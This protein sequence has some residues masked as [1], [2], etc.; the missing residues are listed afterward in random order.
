MYYYKIGLFFLISLALTSCQTST[1]F[2]DD[3]LE[4]TPSSQTSI[5][6][7]SKE[8]TISEENNFS[9]NYA[10]RLPQ[11]YETGN[12]KMILIDPNVRAWGAYDA[13]GNLIRAGLAACG[14]DWCHDT[15]R[16]CRTTTG[17]FRIKNLGN[18][19]CK[20][21]KYPKPNGGGPMPYCMFFH[22]DMAL[23]GS[24]MM[25]DANMSHG[26]VRIPVADAQ[27]I[28]YEFATVGTKVVIKPYAKNIA[29]H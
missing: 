27:W 3:A 17:T 20:S 29:S 8:D 13:Q 11:H 15:G 21:S 25:A 12:E 28:R 22:G 5:V 16:P 6:P 7:L 9:N 19:S 14:A 4:N 18:E 10:E 2:E 26:C 24:P 23:H 1:V